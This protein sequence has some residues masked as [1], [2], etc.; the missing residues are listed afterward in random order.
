MVRKQDNAKRSDGEDAGLRPKGHLQGSPSSPPLAD[1]RPLN[2]LR[3]P[4]G[5]WVASD[6]WTGKERAIHAA[7]YVAAIE[8]EEERKREARLAKR[9]SFA[10]M[11]GFDDH[12]GNGSRAAVSEVAEGTKPAMS[13]VRGAHERSGNVRT[14]A[15][16]VTSSPSIGRITTPPR[17]S[18][19]TLPASLERSIELAAVGSQTPLTHPLP[20]LSGNVRRLMFVQHGNRHCPPPFRLRDVRVDM[21]MIIQPGTRP[22]VRDLGPEDARFAIAEWV[23]QISDDTR[24]QYRKKAKTLIRAAEA[25]GLSNDADPIERTIACK[26]ETL[27][28]SRGYG[29]ALA[30]SAAVEVCSANS[31][32]DFEEAMAAFLIADAVLDDEER[33]TVS[34][35]DSGNSYPHRFPTP[36]FDRVF[37]WLVRSRRQNAPLLRALLV[38]L[39]ASGMR[40]N[41]T[42]D[43]RVAS[44]PNSSAMALTIRNSKHEE[45]GFRGCGPSRTLTFDLVDDDLAAATALILSERAGQSVPEWTKR[46]DA[47]QR[48]L[49]EACFE[50]FGVRP[51][52][53]AE[54]S[55]RPDGK[56]LPKRHAY[57]LHSLRHQFAADAKRYLRD[58]GVPSDEMAVIVAAMMG[59][60]TDETANQHYAKASDGRSGIV[61]P[62]VDIQSQSIVRRLRS[63]RITERTPG[64]HRTFAP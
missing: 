40:R 30:W 8:Q 22:I 5:T 23:Y 19:S 2:E 44:V 38:F 53:P 50:L 64:K 17:L 1:V 47:C 35:A 41:E 32:D 36:H 48:L 62:T 31:Y 10:S 60:A 33:S 51:R 13:E 3:G 20:Q 11:L 54:R 27:S 24:A 25:A 56:V 39:R 15:T 4:D 28:R 21:H 52:N 16:D 7:A 49:R 29:A 9:V 57:R 34:E 26:L 63:D 46:L 45:N 18:E 61:P 55:A 37:E 42:R 59:H 14:S 6:E 12:R 43:F 58:F